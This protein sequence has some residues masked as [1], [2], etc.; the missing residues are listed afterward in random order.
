M[1]EDEFDDAYYD[2]PTK[3]DRMW[4]MIC[5]LSA[6]SGFIGIPL[7]NIIGPLVIWL[8]K[9]D[10]S[11]FID[12]HG[13]EALNFQ[14]SMTIYVIVSFFLMIVLIG[15]VILPV[16]YV[17]G[18]VFVIVAAIKANDGQYFRYPITIRFLK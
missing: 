9:R 16:L 4:A 1:Y 18:L 13:K 2:Q 8:V 3:D 14:T 7:G 6:L 5:H 11:P 15:F 12:A 17:V 10:E